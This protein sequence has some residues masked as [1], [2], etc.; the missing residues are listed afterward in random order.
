MD[1]KGQCHACDEVG[2]LDTWGVRETCTRCAGWFIGG[3]TVGETG[4]NHT[5][6]CWRCDDPHQSIF[7]G[8]Y[9]T[10]E[11]NASCQACDNRILVNNYCAKPCP[12]DKPIMDRKGQC[13]AC[14]EVGPLDT[15]GTTK[16]CLSC[17][18]WFIGG[19]TGGSEDGNPGGRHTQG[20]Y[21]CDDDEPGVNMGI[22]GDGSHTAS[23]Q[24]CPGRILLSGWAGPSLGFGWQPVCAK[25]CAAGQVM[26][27]IGHCHSCFEAEDFE[28]YRV[29]AQYKCACPGVRYL[30]GNI[31]KKCPE[32]LSALTPE[33]QLVCQK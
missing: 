12:P 20:C 28:V 24:N 17:P 5:Q 8:A 14:D 18:G 26:D 31:C 32:D 19:D 29:P 33:Q 25:L 23:C 9:T 13:H 6:G 3:D 11:T 21:R 22:N 10:V 7:L 16:T 27:H 30:D 4:G 15:W 2:P 1:R